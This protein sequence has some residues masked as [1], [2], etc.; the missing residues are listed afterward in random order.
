MTLRGH[1]LALVVCLAAFGCRNDMASVA[2]FETLGGPS[3][4]LG[5]ATLE[6]S[7]EGRLT[8]RLSAARMTRSSEEPPVWEV[9]GGFALD[10]I[11]EDGRLDARLEADQG[12]FLEES[13]F[14]E[15]EGNVVLHGAEG[16]T[17]HTELL[18]WSADSDHVH[19]PAPVEVRTPQGT[20]LGK[21]LESDAR[22]QRYRI[23][24]PTG[25][26][27]VDTTNHRP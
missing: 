20:L 2:D 10:V 11:D 3:Q 1:A 13:R 5:D 15:A 18:Y 17:L 6:Y 22:F 9:S 21:G 16:D 19:T 12:H 4:V 24:E 27:L 23:L 7:E 25:T 14:L 26:F 8:H